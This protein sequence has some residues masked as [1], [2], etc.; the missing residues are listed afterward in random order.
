MA[1]HRRLVEYDR[2]GSGVSQREVDD[3]SVAAQVADLAAVVDTL[4]MV[5]FD[6]GAWDDGGR[7]AHDLTIRDGGRG[8]AGKAAGAAP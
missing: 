8:A 5:R 1:R 2:R 7:A 4:D 6:L 3:L